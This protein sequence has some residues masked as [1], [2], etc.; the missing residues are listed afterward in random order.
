M[1]APRTIIKS[2]TTSAAFLKEFLRAPN[3][4]GAVAPSSPFLAETIVEWIDWSQTSAILE[5]GPGTGAFT[6]KILERKPSDCR[7]IAMEINPDLCKILR[8][9]YPGIEICQESVADVEKVCEGECIEV[10]DCVVSGLPWAVFSDEMQDQFLEAMTC[11]LREGGQFTTFAYVH[12]LVVPA[13]QRFREKL[14]RY[15][16]SVTR[17]KVVW[18]NLPPAFVYRCVR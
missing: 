16:S 14:R 1:G 7:Y 6:R 11:V 9:K 2:V 15:F 12:G 18:L 5:W 13:G 8:E 4:T 10:V 3:V 17:S